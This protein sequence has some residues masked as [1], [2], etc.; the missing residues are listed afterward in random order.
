M[1]I[2]RSSAL[3]SSVVCLIATAL[4]IY[5]IV[6][7]SIWWLIGSVVAFQLYWIIGLSACNHRYYSHG[8]FETTP[9]WREVMLFF[10]AAGMAGHPGLYAIVHNRHHATSDT[11]DD[12]HHY[13]ARNSVYYPRDVGFKLTS[14]EI[15][16][17]VADPVM[18]RMLDNY[19]L[20]PCLVCI[21]LSMIDFSALVYLWAI[22]VVA[23]TFARKWVTLVW[24]HGY[25]YQNFDTKDNS[26]NSK[27]LGALFG[28]EG[29][30]NNHHHKP[31]NYNF[32]SKK[33]EIDPTSWFIELI[34]VK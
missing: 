23:M 29:L 11:D 2:F 10:S 3:K 30:H 17:Y 26:T 32:V 6:D 8:S 22:P 7:F 33:G 18:K 21:V 5:A 15:K 12:P 20:Y 16:K 13:Y 24:M 14:G 25:G 28:G 34:M 19:Y 9:F 1:N 31:G 27:F 4:S